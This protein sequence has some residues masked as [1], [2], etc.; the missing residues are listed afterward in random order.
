MKG[1]KIDWYA[2]PLDWIEDMSRELRTALDDGFEVAPRR[3]L[4]RIEI[5]E[6]HLGRKTKLGNASRRLMQ[7]AG[8]I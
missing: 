5:V 6:A 7:K 2:E 4:A 1:K 8:F 3:L